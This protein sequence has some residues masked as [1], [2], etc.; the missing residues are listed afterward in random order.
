MSIEPVSMTQEELEQFLAEPRNA[1]MGTARRD[2]S[3][4][5]SA[6]WFTYRE[7]KLYTS[8]Y[9]SS[10]KYFNIR[11]NP[12]VAFCVNAAHPDARSVTIYGTAEL[13]GEESGMFKQVERELAFHY[14]ST[15]EAAEAYLAI[16][17]DGASSVLVIT[18]Y[19]IISQVYN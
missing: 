15:S 8:L 5:L 12:K 17:D 18:P 19:K 4:Q 7:G 14:H 6:M 13:I 10:A 11:R 9:Q 2:G 3:P 16:S 1:V